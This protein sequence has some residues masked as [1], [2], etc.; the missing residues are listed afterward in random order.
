[1]VLRVGND[2]VV[3]LTAGVALELVQR[4]YLRQFFGLVVY[5]SD[6]NS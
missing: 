6:T 2:A 3:L 1:M 5:T 4:D